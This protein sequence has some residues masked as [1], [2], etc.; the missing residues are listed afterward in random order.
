MD[1][2]KHKRNDLAEERERLLQENYSEEYSWLIHLEFKRVRDQSSEDRRSAKAF[3][4]WKLQVNQEDH[5]HQLHQRQRA[6]E[7]VPQPHL[8]RQLSWRGILE[9]AWWA[10][11]LTENV[12][13][14]EE[15]QHNKEEEANYLAEANELGIDECW[16]YVDVLA[17]RAK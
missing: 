16:L 3:N 8:E 7:E 17:L 5:E 2:Q 14:P 9:M 6:G 4:P 12:H 10:A 1:N 13:Y 15:S 11:K